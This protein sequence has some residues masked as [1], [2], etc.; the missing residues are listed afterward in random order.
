MNLKPDMVT[1][2]SGK[3]VW[4]MCE[5]KH[6]WKATIAARSKGEG[7]RLCYNLRRSRGSVDSLDR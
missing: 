1:V 2:S 5:Q 3:K 7:C 6:E 4:W